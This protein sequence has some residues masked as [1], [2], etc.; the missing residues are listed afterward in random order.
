M[1]DNIIVS[2][3]CITY[4][5]AIYIIDCLNGLLNQK[6]N[7]KYE[8][9]IHDDVSTDG[10]K[11]I[12]QEYTKTYPELFF[13]IYQKENQY[14]KGI[15]GINSRFNFPRARGK[16]IAICEGDDYWTDP[17]KLQKQVDF[18]E[19]N[20]NFSACV[21]ETNIIN[22]SGNILEEKVNRLKRNIY[23]KDVF[24]KGAWFRNVSLMFRNNIKVDINRFKGINAGDRLLAIHL[25][26]NGNIIGYLPEV[27]CV[28]RKHS[29]GVFSL[30]SN[31]RK[32]KKIY[33]DFKLYQKSDYY[34]KY[35][36]EIN[37]KLSQSLYVIGKYS[38]IEKDFN[39]YFKSLFE[40]ISY[41]S[42]KSKIINFKLFIANFIF[43]F[44]KNEKN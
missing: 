25:T 35:K 10:T 24:E 41:T 23:Q 11:E 14:S 28:Y 36:Y 20:P 37:H 40:V 22:E 6:T 9:L 32:Y 43:P 5:H 19:S 30:I 8:I 33:D 15:R 17:Y 12:I 42:F 31:Y 16:Y 13:P 27:M 21:C 18:L 44:F 34:I 29:G 2:I 38:I 26:D 39:L 1:S 4:N 7:F 3:S